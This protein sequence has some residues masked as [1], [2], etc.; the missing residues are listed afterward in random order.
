MEICCALIEGIPN[1]HCRERENVHYIAVM[2]LL[3]YFK[4]AFQKKRKKFIVTY[5]LLTV[6]PFYHMIRTRNFHNIHVSSFQI[7]RLREVFVYEVRQFIY[8]LQL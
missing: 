2:C 6:V 4:K 3:S 1:I 8:A 5:G 7:K